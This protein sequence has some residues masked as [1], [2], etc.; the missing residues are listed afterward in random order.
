MKMCSSVFL[1]VVTLLSFPAVH[2][3]AQ[4]IPQPTPDVLCKRFRE[5]LEQPGLKRELK[6]PHEFLFSG[7]VVEPSIL[8]TNASATT[9]EV[10]DLAQATGI[11][12]TTSPAAIRDPYAIRRLPESDF[13]SFPTLVLLAGE[14]RAFHFTV[15]KS[16]AFD[17]IRGETLQWAPYSDYPAGQHRYSV[18]MGR[19]EIFGTYTTKLPQ[20]EDFA[21]VE[22]PESTISDSRQKWVPIQV[23]P[24]GNY[25]RLVILARV[26]EEL[27]LFSGAA[28]LPVETYHSWYRSATSPDQDPNFPPS[29]IAPLRLLNLKGNARF[30]VSKSQGM[31]RQSAFRLILDNGRSFSLSNLKQRYNAATFSLEN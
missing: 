24:S 30:A 31:T 5:L 10:P 19:I 23:S 27:V 26:E 16:A 2:A 3:N 13:C 11:F 14:T 17:E 4:T 6:L 21:C 28:E 29:K 7:E 12:V 25:C 18:R 15:G 20:I 9:M 22:K 1:T 8:L